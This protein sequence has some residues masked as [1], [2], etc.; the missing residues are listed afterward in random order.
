MEPLFDALR[1]ETD[2][3]TTEAGDPAIALL[4]VTL[5]ESLEARRFA[6]EGGYPGL[7]EFLIPATRLNT[8][9][10]VTRVEG[11]IVRPRGAPAPWVP[12]L[13]SMTQEKGARP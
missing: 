3:A 13:D 8:Q 5:P 6:F 9:A 10:H 1:A 12:S 2:D 4:V 7:Q 11:R